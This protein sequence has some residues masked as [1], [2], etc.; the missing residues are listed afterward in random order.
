M[1]V[2]ALVIF[3]VFAG[4]LL[5][6]QLAL[7][8]PATRPA[9]APLNVYVAPLGESGSLIRPGWLSSRFTN[10]IQNSLDQ[11][12]QVAI[13]SPAVTPSTNRSATIGE[14]LNSA[15]NADAEVA[16]IGVVHA[17]ADKLSVSGD[18]Y[19]ASSGSSFGRFKAGGTTQ[20][21]FAIQDSVTRQIH[22]I[23]ANLA[24]AFRHTDAHAGR[25]RHEI[26]GVRSPGKRQ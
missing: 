23:V 15:R 5:L 3:L 25:R 11:I 14:I 20:D 1:K 18:I 17:E 19:D 26:R 2:R 21:L 16:V 9:G 13:V 12:K 24:A 8:A 6:A 10:A 22:A 7:A 4:A